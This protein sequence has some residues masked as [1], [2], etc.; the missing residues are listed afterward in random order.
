VTLGDRIRAAAVVV[1]VMAM[2]AA[3]SD[4]ASALGV[5]VVGILGGGRPV[6]PHVGGGASPR[7]PDLGGSRIPA[8]T[9]VMGVLTVAARPSVVMVDVGGA[10]HAGVVLHSLGNLVRVSGWS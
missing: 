1:G 3:R 7:P 8:S 9:T 10:S 6:L 2:V 5:V 4:V